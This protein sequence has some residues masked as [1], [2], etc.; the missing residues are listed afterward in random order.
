M[1]RCRRPHRI[2]TSP[3]SS[4]RALA[5]R[6]RQVG[7]GEARHDGVAQLTVQVAG[8]IDGTRAADL[9]VKDLGILHA[10]RIDSI[11]AQANRPEFLVADGNGS[12]GAPLLIDLQTSR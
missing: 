1:R 7:V 2:R 5:A 11:S 4:A 6:V 8:L 10:I 12:R 9:F 3:V